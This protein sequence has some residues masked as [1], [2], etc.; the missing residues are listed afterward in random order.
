VPD[1]VKAPIVRRIFQLYGEGKLGT[2]AIARRL[3]S[4]GAP[5]PR[6]Q[7]WSP[8][9]LQLILANPAY[10]GLVRWRG[11][12]HPGLHKPLVDDDVFEKARAILRSRGENASLRRGNPSDFLLSGLVRCHHCG[13]AYVGT[14]AHGRSARYTYYA[15]STR[16]KYGAGRCNGQRL[17]KDRLET[18]VLG[19]LAELYRDGSLVQRAIAE[20]ARRAVEEH[21]QLTEQLASTCAEITRLERKLERYF[22][23]FEIANSQQ[24][25]ARSASAASVT[26]SNPSAATR[27]T[28]P[29]GSPHKPS[30]RRTQPTSRAS[31]TNSTRSS[32]PEFRNRQRNSSACSSR[33]SAS[34]T[35]AG[36][37]RPIGFRRRFAQCLVRW[38]VLGSNQ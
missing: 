37:S 19:Q 3:E 17:P 7:G 36:L 4:E 5:A 28:S 21:P 1:P 26:A 31:L 11:E 38:A 25:S 29:A 14:S 9:A 22:E 32:P 10:R 23:A 6:K 20:A 16:Y 2:T 34:T 18:A 35:A 33:R 27:P 8:N 13:R 24:P 30:R 15:C 12:T